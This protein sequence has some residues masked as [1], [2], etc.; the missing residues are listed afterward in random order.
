M[1]RWGRVVTAMVTPFD[2]QGRL[3]VD[4]AVRLARWLAEH[5]NDG[6]VVTG[7]TGEAPVLTDDEKVELW[8]AVAEAVT[9]PV[10][11]G[12][13]TYDTHHSI[14]L[15]K[16]A[17]S[18]GVAGILAVTPYY[19]RPSQDGIAAHMRA[20]AGATTLPVM[21]YDIPIRTG[22]KIA[23][24]TL[25][26]L[27]EDAPNVVAVKDAAGSPADSARLVAEAP[28]S[29]E[30]YSGDDAQ[31]LPFLAVGG[32]GVVSV[33][34]HWCGVHLGEMI[35]AFER[36]DL[37]KAREINARLLPSF[38]FETSDENPNPVPTKAMLRVLGLPG[39]HCR[40]PNVEVDGDALAARAKAVA[41]DLGLPVA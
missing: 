21:V 5:G 32:V 33:A 24:H 16:R 14:E 38:A 40:L 20:V 26:R 35:A 31:T 17:E 10:I 41:A 6:L 4:G 30:L 29:F 9:I 23:I 28:Q 12:T 34:G 27:A 8:R 11:A 15:T 2:D 19:N 3:D 13:G 1:A 39:G 7:T 22:R 18:C 37:A 25:L 36:G